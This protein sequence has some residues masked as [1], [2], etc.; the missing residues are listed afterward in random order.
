L[1]IGCRITDFGD[2]AGKHGNIDCDNSHNA[3]YSITNDLF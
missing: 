3:N 1:H 2:I